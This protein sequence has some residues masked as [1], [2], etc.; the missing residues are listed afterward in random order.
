MITIYFPFQNRQRLEFAAGHLL[1]SVL[2][3]DF[4]IT[5]DADFYRAQTG[6][7][8]NYSE[9][10][11]GRGVWIVP[12]GLLTEDGVEAIQDLQ[13]GEWEGTFC[14][15]R[16]D[17]GDVPFDIFAATFYLLSLYEEYLPTDLDE[18]GRFDH[19][20]SLLYREGQL[21][22]AVVD[23]WA[24][25]LKKVL[26]Q[27][28]GMAEKDFRLRTYRAIETYDIDHPYLYRYKGFIKTAG[29]ILRDV[30]RKNFV[31]VRERWSVLL[32]RLEDPYMRALKA[33]KEVQRGGYWFVLMEK[34][35]KYGTGLVHV[36][37]EYYSYIKDLEG[38]T[39]GLHPSYRTAEDDA[40]QLRVSLGV[41]KRAL[42]E[43]L[44]R[45]VVCSRRHF[46]Q[47]R[48]PQTFRA[49]REVGIRED[50]TLAFAKAPGFRS[51]TATPHYFYDVEREE[52]T[53]LLLRPTVMMDS[54]LLVHLK[55]SPEDALEKIK[56]LIDVCKQSGG[57]Y[58]SLWHNSN[59]ARPEENPWV[60]VFLES[61][62]YAISME[63]N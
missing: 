48:T 53:D 51:G 26:E 28:G 27:K 49:L 8:I 45:P 43:V 4:C 23:R 37:E 29:G 31:A 32:G 14:F 34:E 56:R 10:D 24:Y 11:L 21:E 15:F 17:R 1:D 42:E 50:F 39:V 13:K 7:G 9:E 44:G 33:I 30:W 35:G 62:R 2:G 6:G 19:R 12:Q 41:E 47:M 40:W 38:V 58:V 25:Q 54:T 20:S 36:P 46:L 55:L 61:R 5:D 59:L 52:K 22:A 60:G 57:D 63:N 18:H 3:A 16:N